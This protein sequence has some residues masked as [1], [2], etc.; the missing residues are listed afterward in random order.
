MILRVCLAADPPGFSTRLRRILEGRELALSVQRGS[1]G[2]RERLVRDDF[3]VVVVSRSL[4]EPQ[5]ASAVT[6]IR[7]LPDPPE[8]IVLSDVE[9][10]EGRAAL[11]AAGAIA[12]VNPGLPDPTLAET[13]LAL[14]RRCR[15]DAM[16]RLRETTSERRSGL[17][18]LVAESPAMQRFL[19]LARRLV[20]TDSSLLIL[21]ETGVGKERVARAIHSDG[22]RAAGPFIAVN[23]AALPESLLESELFG[24]EQGAFTGASRSRRGYFEVAHGGTLFLDEV[25]ETP[26]HVQVK[27]LRA[28]QERTIQRV[29]G[30]RPIPVNVRVMAATNRELEAEVKARRFRDDLY[31]RLAVVTLTIPPLRERREDIP[32]LVS[33]YLDRFRVRLTRPVRSVSPEALEALV[34]HDWPGNV[35]ELIN[36]IER[37]VLLCAGPEIGLQDLPNNL[38]AARPRR[39]APAAATAEPAVSIDRPL[40]EIRAEAVAALEHQ[41][42]VALLEAAR[43]RI[44]EV[45]RRAG[46]NERSL[47][48]LMR[49][50]GL[51]KEP[52]RKSTS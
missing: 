12:V 43:G 9:D 13:L 22:P 15:E 8:V 5:A 14:L 30:E 29:G 49:R 34:A 20:A 48:A 50:H 17:D 7:E 45:A 18:D 32:R 36:V 19:G 28:L 26:P 41:Y 10:A 4:L 38:L 25:G 27:L 51:R 52:F 1:H 39:R 35:R 3:D 44:G 47:Y 2:L 33:V 21:G 24:H 16:R 6:L 42:L 31:Y 23:C 40:R 37:A 46:L 11:L